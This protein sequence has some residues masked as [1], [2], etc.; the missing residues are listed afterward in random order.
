M[1]TSTNEKIA[2][3]YTADFRKD[4]A[5]NIIRETQVDPNNMEDSLQD[6]FNTEHVA[7]MDLSDVNNQENISHDKENISIYNK[8]S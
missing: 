8:D 3:F 2:D 6:E 5:Q 1:L 7:P 4:E